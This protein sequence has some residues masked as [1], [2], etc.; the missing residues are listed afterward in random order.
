MAFPFLIPPTELLL[1]DG[2]SKW[3]KQLWVGTIAEQIWDVGSDSEIWNQP[4]LFIF[5]INLKFK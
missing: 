3:R 5:R 2:F 4:I 1:A